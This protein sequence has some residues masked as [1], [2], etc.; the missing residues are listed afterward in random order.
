MPTGIISQIINQSYVIRSVQSELEVFVP[1][2]EFALK[3]TFCAAVIKEKKTIAYTHI[4]EIE[5][6]QSHPVYQNLK[7]ESYIGTPI[8]INDQVYGTLS[9][10]ST[11]V[12]NT[13]FQPHELEIVELMAQSLGSFIAAHQAEIERQQAEAALQKLTSE[14]EKRVEQRTAEL[15]L[16]CLERQ[17][18]EERY[19]SL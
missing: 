6:M 1:Q 9:F 16:E 18:S 5:E 3:D 15:E 10:S 4:G 17:R 2:L 14:L 8:L 19:R 13:D 7:L 12:R 11:E